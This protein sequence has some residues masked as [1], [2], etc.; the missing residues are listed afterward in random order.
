MG[1]E[2]VAEEAEVVV[3]DCNRAH[4]PVLTQLLLL[5]LRVR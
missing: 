3:A 5:A 2:V 4:N 1:V